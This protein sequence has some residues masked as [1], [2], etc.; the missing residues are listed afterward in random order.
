MPTIGTCLWFDDQAEE[1]AQFYT[2]IFEGSRI[3]R[4]TPYTADTP[5]SKPVGSVA[6]VEFDLEG[7]P[8]TG[9]NGGPDFT[10]NEAISLVVQT[11]SQ[12]ESDRYW[13]ALLEGGGTPS[14]C[15]WL[16]DRFGVS[17]QVY[18]SELDDLCRDPDPGR[19]RR[20][21]EAMLTQT[22]IDIEAIRAAM[23]AS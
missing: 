7:R 21:T 2:S 22:K 18:P 19:A 17:W 13:Y 14:V 23:D 15:G 12:E 4:V 9:L 16:K 20:A 3:T 10:F 8:F 6:T 1:A 11:E 5:S